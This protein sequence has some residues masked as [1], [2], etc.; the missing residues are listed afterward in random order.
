MDI[1]TSVLSVF[2]AMGEWIG[3]AFTDYVIP[4]F[5]TAGSGST[6]GSLTLMGVLAVAG[7]SISVA[8]LLLNKFT[9]FLGFRG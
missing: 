1:L 7:L 9:D 5:Y 8:M 6:A 2:T 3:T 4:I